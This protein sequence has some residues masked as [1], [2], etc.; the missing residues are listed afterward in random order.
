MSQEIPYTEL[1]ESALRGV[2]EDFVL[3][4]GTDYGEVELSLERK[5]ENVKKLLVAGKAKICFD[6]ESETCSIIP[7]FG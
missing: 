6:P 5:V 2:I 3:R 1:T 7:S 4:E